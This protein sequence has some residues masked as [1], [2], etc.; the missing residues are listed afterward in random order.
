MSARLGSSDE[1][2]EDAE[3]TGYLVSPLLDRLIWGGEKGPRGRARELVGDEVIL[4]VIDPVE[5][6][7]GCCGC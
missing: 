6:D 2:R 3:R 4:G 7:R 1:G 5:F